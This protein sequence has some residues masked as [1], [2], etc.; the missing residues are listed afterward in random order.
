M[1]S[2]LESAAV[3]EGDKAEP[4]VLFRQYQKLCRHRAQILLLRSRVCN[5][6]QFCKDQYAI[7]NA[8]QTTL[9]TTVDDVLKGAARLDA[10]KELHRELQ[11]INAGIDNYTDE[12]MKLEYGL[13][14]DESLL[15]EEE[16]SF[17]RQLKDLAGPNAPFDV[18]EETEHIRLRAGLLDELYFDE[19]PSSDAPSDELPAQLRDYYDTVAAARRSLDNLDELESDYSHA[20][21]TLE[22]QRREGRQMDSDAIDLLRS[23]PQNRADIVKQ[24]GDFQDAIREKRDICL[25]AAIEAKTSDNFEAHLASRYESL[26]ATGGAGGPSESR[27]QLVVT[28]EDPTS[29]PFELLLAR[30]PDLHDRVNEWISEAEP[31]SS[32]SSPVRQEP[33]FSDALNLSPIISQD[34]ASSFHSG[35]SI[36][37]CHT[38]RTSNESTNTLQRARLKQFRVLKPARRRS[39]PIIRKAFSGGSALLSPQSTGLSW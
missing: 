33:E 5:H 12:L 9:M 6:R 24:I 27:D 30:I 39:E 32:A 36:E 4:N 10:V 3:Q 19:S 14:S 20:K 25:E 38:E 16:R 11:E 18:N 26:K 7:A 2:E 13:S 15:R 29:D 35:R 21:A 34:L 8:K 31:T 17:Y 37:A 1:K 28:L 23:Y 22:V